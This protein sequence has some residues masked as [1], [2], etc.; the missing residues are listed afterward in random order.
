M[1]II[2]IIYWDMRENGKAKDILRRQA[3]AAQKLN[4]NYLL[5]RIYDTLGTIAM[6]EHRYSEAL[7]CK[8]A[9]QQYRVLLDKEADGKLALEME[10]KYKTAEKEKALSLQRLSLLQKDLQVQKSRHSLYYTLAASLV[11]LLLAFLLYLRTRHKKTAH[12][13]E[14]RSLQQEKEIQLLQA[15]MQGEERERSRIAKDLHDGVAGLLAA[16]KMHFSSSV[17]QEDAAYRKAVCLLDNVT[18][19]VRKTSHNLM[20]DVLLQHGLNIALYRY[21][22]NSSTAS[23]PVQYEFTGTEQRFPEGFELSVY[24]LVQE[25]LNTRF[26]HSDATEATVQMHMQ[27]DRLSITME[28]NRTGFAKR[29]GHSGDT[30]WAS[31]KG[32]IRAL[33]GSLTFSETGSGVKAQLAFN[34][35]GLAVRGESQ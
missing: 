17:T 13:K 11:V 19:D 20:P 10:V 1:A 5:Q 28:D 33:N 14:L 7:A 32:R 26:R 4:A 29:P 34:V 30:G 6:S 3:A 23:L 22:N 27:A 8:K 15:L 12:Q 35:E 24:R 9:A 18:A 31:L 16:V 2:G 25:L 21:C